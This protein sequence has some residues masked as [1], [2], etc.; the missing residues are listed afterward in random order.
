MKVKIK[1][2]II[3][4]DDELNRLLK[5]YLEKVG[6]EVVSTLNPVEGIEIAIKQKPDFIILDIM[7]PGMDGFEVCRTIRQQSDVPIVMLTAR[8][9]V[10]DR[11]VGLEFGA[12]DYMPKPFEPRELDARI[13]AILRRSRKTESA[14]RFQF[15][16]LN[17]YPERYA[18]ELDGKPLDVSTFEFDLLLLLARNKGRVLSRDAIMDSLRGID[19]SAFDR[20]VDMLISRLR[21]KL[22]DDPKNPRFIRTIRNAGYIFIGE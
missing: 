4:D 16:E 10:T 2:L 15:G 22:N 14:S 13:K 7:M 5:A 20:S 1:I 18:A 3:D 6:Y 11:V 17:L 12:D 8:G 21:Q 19:W 9:E